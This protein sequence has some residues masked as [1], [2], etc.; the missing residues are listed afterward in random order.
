VSGEV[1]ER[2]KLSNYYPRGAYQTKDGYLA[3]HSPDNIIWG[4]LCDAMGHPELKQDERSATARARCA[5][6]EF[7]DPILNGY[8]ASMTRDEAVETLNAAGVP[9]GPVNTA[10]DIFADPHVAAR[11][12]LVDIDDPDVGT[13]KFARTTPHLSAAPEPPLVAAPRLGQHTRQILEQTLEYLPKDIDGL[14]ASGAIGLDE[15]E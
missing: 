10:E 5:N 8:L 3:L 2:G 15:A 7:L 4:R 14:A 11:R 9:C 12:M 1:G 13:Y 6:T